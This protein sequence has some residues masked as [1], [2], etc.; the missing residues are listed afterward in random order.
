MYLV[1]VLDAKFPFE[2][3]GVNPRPTPTEA[4]LFLFKNRA[5]L[6]LADSI[7]NKVDEA[8]DCNKILKD[9]Q[10]ANIE[11]PCSR[12]LHQPPRA[13]SSVFACVQTLVFLV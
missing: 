13:Q 10:V 4:S 3:E 12:T 1:K 8:D 7:F 9:I 11:V 5:E 6:N 2:S